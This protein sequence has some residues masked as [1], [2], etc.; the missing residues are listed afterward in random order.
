M[1]QHYTLGDVLKYE[2]YVIPGIPVFYVYTNNA[3]V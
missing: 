3:Y 2:K 1:N